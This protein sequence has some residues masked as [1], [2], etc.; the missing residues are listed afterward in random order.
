MASSADVK[1]LA[2]AVR[3]EGID[4]SQSGAGRG[5][6]TMGAV[7]A[8]AVLQR[9]NRYVA[10]VLPRARAVEDMRLDTTDQVLAAIADG[11]V[12]E[13]FSHGS[14]ARRQQF[15][16][17]AEVLSRTGVQTIQELA[18]AL[19]DTPSAVSRELR[20]VKHVGDKT[21][22]YLPMLCGLDGV[23]VDVH[24]RRFAADAGLPVGTYD[25]CRQLYVDAAAELNVSPGAL[26]R[27][28]WRHMS[29]GTRKS[30]RPRHARHGA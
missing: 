9:R 4:L 20:A 27:A 8:D 14:A 29:G 17:M 21:M 26:D 13:A 11:T 25:E 15:C 5:W 24:L 18:R 10:A 12:W 2:A 30:Q 6:H 28:V 3:S 19:R 1:T 22:N 16:D 23:A 7:L